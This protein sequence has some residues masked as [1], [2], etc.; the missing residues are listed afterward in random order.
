MLNRWSHA[1]AS[2]Q[3][4]GDGRKLLVSR[5]V[6]YGIA[7]VTVALT[8]GVRLL[9][10]P[11]L[12]ISHPY[13]FFYAA[14]AITAWYGGFWPSILSIVLAYVGAYL[15]FESPQFGFHPKYFGVDDVLGLI[16]FLFSGLA[17]AL[18]IRE[19]HLSRQRAEDRQRQ[20]V[21]Q[22]AERKRIQKQ[23]EHTQAELQE[24]AAL[25]ER[26]VEERT[27]DLTQTIQSLEGVCYHIAH[28][29]RAPLRAMNGFTTLLMESYAPQFDETGK[30]YARRVTA[31]ASQMDSLIKDLLE[32]G[33]LGHAKMPMESIDLGKA[34]DGALTHLEADINASHAD[35]RVCR[36]LYS[37]CANGATLQQVLVNLLSNALKFVPPGIT[38]RVLVWSGYN[39]GSIRLWIEDNGI[40]IAPQYYNKIFHVFERL[41]RTDEYPGTGIGLAIAS[42]GVERMGGRLG[43]ESQPGKGSRF[44]IELPVPGLGNGAE[45]VGP[46]QFIGENI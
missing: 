45:V 32:Y 35:V 18:I 25:L 1:A 12:G 10:N 31:S 14:I 43:V 5:V 19:L 13:T 42:K 28:D 40:G 39:D 9:F 34:M 38:P 29:L 44:W 11:W 3:R 2:L 4:Q 6:R 46:G 33:R 15:L 7:V 30:E 20:L 24:H 27:S 26:R 23:L 21:A 36:P 8:A 41:H 22:I 37:V 16:G 17:I